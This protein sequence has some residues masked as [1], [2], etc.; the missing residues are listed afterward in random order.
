MRVEMINLESHHRTVL[1]YEDFQAN[2]G[3]QP[4]AFTT[5]YLEKEF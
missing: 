1:S 2:V 4:R 5:G 3:V